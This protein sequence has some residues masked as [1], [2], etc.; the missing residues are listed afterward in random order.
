MFSKSLE[1]EEEEK[2]E[3]VMVEVEEEEDEEV[4]EGGDRLFFWVLH[5]QVICNLFFPVFMKC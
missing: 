5:G 1:E 4:A 2:E 3:L